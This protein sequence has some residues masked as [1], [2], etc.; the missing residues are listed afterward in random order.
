MSILEPSINRKKPF[1]EDRWS[2]ERAVWV[3]SERE[4][5]DVSLSMVYDMCYLVRFTYREDVRLRK[6]DLEGE[7][8]IRLIGIVHR[9]LVCRGYTCIPVVSQVV[10]NLSHQVYMIRDIPGARSD[11][12]RL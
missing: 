3:I 10:I 12:C 9:R 2:F 1:L 6:R 11:I 7:E 5:C 4:G 8:R